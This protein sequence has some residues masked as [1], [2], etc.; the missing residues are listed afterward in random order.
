PQPT[1]QGQLISIAELVMLAFVLYLILLAAATAFSAVLL[2]APQ[3][4]RALFA[5]IRRSFY[6]K[7]FLFF[8]AGAVVP[9]VILAVV[10]RNYFAA[11]LDASAAENAARTVTTAQRLVEDYAALQA[12]GTTALAAI[13]GQVMGLV[14]RA[15]AADVN[16]FDRSRLQATSARDLFASRLLASRTPADLYRPTLP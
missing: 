1:W 3:S 13:D 14:R 9:V 4:V 6:H 15:G 5:E 10:T 16:L 2:R 8:V 11:Q 12:R 7:L